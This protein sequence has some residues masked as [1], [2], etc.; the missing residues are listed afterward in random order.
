[1]TKTPPKLVENK[2]DEDE[3]SRFYKPKVA[4]GE[5]V[6]PEAKRI[7]KKSDTLLNYLRREKK[8][9]WM[10]QNRNKESA[11]MLEITS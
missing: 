2:H 5:P 6:D 9:S 11:T 8:S 1:M 3:Y 7:M 10:E 4:A